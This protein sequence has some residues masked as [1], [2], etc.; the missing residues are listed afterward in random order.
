MHRITADT[1]VI[2][3]AL[4]FPGKPRRVLNLAEEGVISLALS[5]PIL[6][7]V[8]RVL[9]RPKFGWPE[10]QIVRALDQISRFAEHAAPR[11]ALSV[12]TADPSD[13]RILE[14][15][16]AARSNYIVSGDNHLV[17]LARFEQI[18]IVTPADFLVLLNRTQP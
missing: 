2:I 9:R 6:D 4:N 15:A 10:D 14:C 5:R 12:I 13:N 7:E 16:V 3:S 11:R 8:A 1:N 17:K 18:E